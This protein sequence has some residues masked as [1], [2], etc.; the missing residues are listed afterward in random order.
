MLVRSTPRPAADLICA[1]RQPQSCIIVSLKTGSNAD[2]MQWSCRV[3]WGALGHGDRAPPVA[4]DLT[5][6]AFSSPSVNHQFVRQLWLHT[7]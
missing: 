5:Y 3:D 2:L 6:A 1:M 7:L 4:F